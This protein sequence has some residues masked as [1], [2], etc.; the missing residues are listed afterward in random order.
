MAWRT[1]ASALLCAAAGVS[2]QTLYGPVDATGRTAFTD[3]TYTSP[4]LRT[5][6]VSALDVANALSNHSAISSR[7][8]AVIDTNEAA[9][10]LVQAQLERKQGAQPLPREQAQGTRVV[11]HL[12]WRR[13]EKLRRVVEHA[14]RRLN[15]TRASHRAPLRK[16][17]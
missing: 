1:C 3:Q 17:G 7:R 8:S 11:N 16:P 13:Q 10:S 5:A 15:E 6:T 9:R 4:S 2:A 12:Y 14:Q